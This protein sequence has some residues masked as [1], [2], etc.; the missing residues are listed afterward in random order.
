MRRLL[1][2]LTTLCCAAPIQAARPLITDDARTVDPYACQVEAWVKQ[3]SDGHEVWAVPAC[4]PLGW[5]EFALGGGRDSQ[6]G[7][8]S[9]DYQMQFKTLFQRME[10]GGWGVGLAVGKVAHPSAIPGQNGLG[11][12]Y[13]YLPLSLA[14][15]DDKLFVHL[16]LGAVRD[17]DTR[18]TRRTWGLGA[19]AELNARWVLIAEMFGDHVD[20]GNWQAGAR[21]WAIPGKLQFDATYGRQR[22]A[23]PDG[24]WISVG[25][26]WL[27]DRLF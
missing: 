8:H 17:R 27:S 23:G 1:L 15:A 6:D 21:Y 3:R 11:N 7:Q 4:N 9:S 25:I 12:H 19:E 16:N 14:L 24:R 18:T 13:F 20:P 26:R 5:F 2:L 22:Q 10:P